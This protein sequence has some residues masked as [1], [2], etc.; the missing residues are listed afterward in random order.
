VETMIQK[1]VNFTN[2][3]NATGHANVQMID[4]Y[5]SLDKVENNAINEIDLDY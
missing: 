4:Y 5:Q 3:M 2:I 1:N